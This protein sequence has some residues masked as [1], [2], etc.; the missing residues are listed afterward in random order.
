MSDGIDSTKYDIDIIVP[1][2]APIFKYPPLIDQL[3]VVGK[4]S[5]YNWPE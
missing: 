5:Y 1:N 3:V 2:A 4:T